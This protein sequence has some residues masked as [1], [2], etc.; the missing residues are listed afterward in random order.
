MS[1]LIGTFCIGIAPAMPVHAA[2]PAVP[3][4]GTILQQ[5]EPAAPPAPP[6]NDTGLRIQQPASGAL[7][8]SIAIHIEHID[9][10]GNTKI[11]TATL[12]ALVADAE[13]KDLD[14]PHIGELAARITDY[15]HAHGFP[16]AH[17]IVPAQTLQAG[18]VKIEVIEARYGKI[19][20][21]NQSRV[22][23]GL[24]QSTL[25]G[26]QSGDVITQ[27]DLDRSLLLLA[28]IAGLVVN[29]T[30]KSGAQA[31]TSDLIVDAA[32]APMFSGNLTLDNGGDAYTGRI[33]GGAN[34]DVYNL[35]HRGDTLGVSALT[36]GDGMRYGRASYDALLDGSGTQLGGAYSALDYKLN[37]S[38]STLDARGSAQTS[39]VWLKQPIVRSMTVNVNAQL[40]YDH[41]QLNDEIRSTGIQTDRHLD[42][43]TATLSGDVRDGLWGGGLSLWS[44]GVT[45]GHV[46]FDNAVAQAE[47]AL[48]TN[49]QGSFVKG[50]ATLTRL[51][52]V[53]ARD[54][55][56]VNLTGQWASG[57]L[58][59]SQK[60]TIGG[61]NSVRAYDVGVLSGDTG[62]TFTTELRHAFGPS[63]YGQWEAIAFVDAA[64]VEVNR[65]ALLASANSVNLGGVGLGLNW[66]GPHRLAANLV[67]AM[68]VG[69]TP[70]QIG[71]RSSVRAW[72]LASEAF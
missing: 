36:S 19:D 71:S 8:P 60:L 9:I 12:H 2:G 65:D 28:D 20:I 41:L 51:Q 53:T 68:P 34:A 31:G 27:A 64:H 42:N 1:L 63:A 39:S 26:L 69:P 6:S 16:L 56:Y 4:A 49:T 3:S 30:L 38:L 15:Y 18:T 14:L 24:L 21:D 47:D 48:T 67:V 7:P 70:V 43:L 5:V 11:D 33:R 54:T 10:V 50:N 62:Y 29:A 37:G 25:G 13:G 72:L 32:S 35:L 46:R 66:A 57:N 44:A 40:E 52:T 59:A 23:D 45:D 22:S 58:D 17:A 55:L 61:P